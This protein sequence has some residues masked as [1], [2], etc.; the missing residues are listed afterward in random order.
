[1]NLAMIIACMVYYLVS[2]GMNCTDVAR[3]LGDAPR[4]VAY[5][6][7]RFEDE[8]LAGLAEG[9]R[10]GRPR[11]LSQAQ[12]EQGGGGQLHCKGEEIHRLSFFQPR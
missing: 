7:R 8:G 1:M 12:L 5:R 11:R 2:Q 6:V 4:T 9:E 10:S 3:L